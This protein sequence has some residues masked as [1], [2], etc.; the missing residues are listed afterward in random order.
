[1]ED[2]NVEGQEQKPEGDEVTTVSVEDFNALKD[3]F[4]QL[5]STN[6]R[7]LTES[8]KHKST[9]KKLMDEQD[10]RERS[11][12]EAKGEIEE[13]LKRERDKRL[14]VETKYKTAQKKNLLKSI[15]IEVSRHAG[16]AYDVRDVLNS[17][18]L[19]EDMVD[20]E[21][22]EVKGVASMVDDLRKNKA[23]LF[24]SGAPGMNQKVPKYEDKEVDP[25][26]ELS[27]GQKFNQL[28]EDIAKLI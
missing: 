11:E 23:Y 20:V 5:Q 7:L 21:T 10:E 19:T 16:D 9:A 2:V 25:Y 14:E 24:K 27:K 18:D 3:Q 22:G 1:M 6:E 17:L 15:Q 12:L 28:A 26:D 8:K 4:A 13:L